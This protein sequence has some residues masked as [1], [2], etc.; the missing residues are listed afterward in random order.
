MTSCNTRC[1]GPRGPFYLDLAVPDLAYAAEYNG[2][3]WHD[4]DR[5]L[6]DAERQDWLVARGWIVDVFE[7]G[8][9]YGHGR[10]PSIRLSLGI[11]RARRRFGSLAWRGQNRDGDAWLG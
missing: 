4:D 10:D 8:D 3:R 6:A 11:E 9:V 2:A 7:D 1:V 5:K